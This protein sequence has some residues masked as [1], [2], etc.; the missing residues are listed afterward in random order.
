MQ[1]LYREGDWA[2]VTDGHN[3]FPI[4]RERYQ[5]KGY[6]PPFDELPTREQYEVKSA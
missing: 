1:G 4:P 3:A 5:N 6:K 2:Q